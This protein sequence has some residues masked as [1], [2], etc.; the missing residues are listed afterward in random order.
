[1]IIRMTA[2]ASEADIDYVVRRMASLGFTTHLTRDGAV[3]VVG[4]IGDLRSFDPAS[5]ATLRG[6]E[7]VLPMGRAFWMAS[8]DYRERDSVVTVRDCTVGG[9]E[10]AVMA[11][12]CSVEGRDQL[13][14]TAWAVRQAGAR[15]LRGG[16]FKPRTS[17]YSFQG[18]AEA[19][20][21]LLAEARQET[22]L[23]IVTEVMAPEQVGLVA[24]Y[25]DVLQVGTR[26][27]QNFPLLHACGEAGMPVLLKRGMMATLEELLLSAEYIMSHG[28]HQVIL[29]ERGIRTFETATRNTLDINAVPVLKELTHLPVVVDPS[30]ATGKSSLVPAVSRAAVAAGADGLLIEVHPEP[31]RAWSDG[32]QSLDLYQFESMMES[33]QP[34]ARAVGRSL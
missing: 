19:G 22:G 17:P 26:N 4:V 16:A 15:L 11:G 13:M 8:R 6:V 24:Q 32:P 14:K 9:S 10:V 3:T 21:E 27:M 25:A 34:L 18:M 33:L 29:C 7:A 20:L 5:V 12:P 2:G 28:N 30:H 31:S 1:M 23:P